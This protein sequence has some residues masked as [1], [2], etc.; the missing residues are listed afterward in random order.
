[1]QTHSAGG[2]FG[3]LVADERPNLVKAIVCV[4]GAEFPFETLTHLPRMRMQATAGTAITL[5]A[6]CVLTLT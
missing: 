2:P 3:W 6:I 4:E 5:A 1:M